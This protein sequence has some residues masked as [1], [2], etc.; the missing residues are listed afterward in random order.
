MRNTPTPSSTP[1]LFNR[2]HP[3]GR[4]TP[5][6]TGPI[7][8]NTGEMTTPEFLEAIALQRQVNQN[9]INLAAIVAHQGLDDFR[10]QIQ[11]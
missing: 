7:L 8:L 2:F 6:T 9:T 5:N 10:I 3:D 4:F 11:G 1:N